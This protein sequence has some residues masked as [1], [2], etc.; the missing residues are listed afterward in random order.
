M[1]PLNLFFFISD[2]DQAIAIAEKIGNKQ[3]YRECST[4]TTTTSTSTSTRKRTREGDLAAE[5]MF[6]GE[7]LFTPESFKNPSVDN[8]PTPNTV[9]S[10][11]NT[12]TEAREMQKKFDSYSKEDQNRLYKYYL[13]RINGLVQKIENPENKEEPEIENSEKQA[14][15]SEPEVLND[16]FVQYLDDEEQTTD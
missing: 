9:A 15:D 5:L 7:N 14:D 2:I 11:K 12:P 1:S 16:E 13:N 10:V 3:T 4:T 6:S 8:T